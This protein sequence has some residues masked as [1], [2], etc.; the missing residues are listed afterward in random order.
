LEKAYAEWNETGREGRDGQNAYASLYGGWMQDVDAQV[1]G[2]AAT[3]Y[4]PASD[5]VSEP[6]VIAA[7]QGGA[8]VTAGIFQ[9]GNPATFS[10][11]GL[12]N[13]HA[14]EVIG[15]DADPASATF[16]TFQL[17]NPWGSYEPAPLTWS[18][19]C[20]YC[21]LLAVADGECTVPAAGANFQAPDAAGGEVHAAALAAVVASGQHM[22]D[23]A[24][25][26][27]AG[28]GNSHFMD[29]AQDARIRALEMV[30]AESGR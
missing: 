4:S 25:V 15:Y 19:L 18:E 16:G 12:V 22:P 27:F 8:A 3:T 21:P 10:Q 9:S 5:P 14:Y 17:E 20:A 11:L 26:D 24:W 30:L 29:A 23:A 7:L 13:D 2:A 1:L 6:A 28:N